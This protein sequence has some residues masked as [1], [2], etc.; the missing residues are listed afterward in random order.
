MLRACAGL[1]APSADEPHSPRSHARSATSGQARPGQGI[2]TLGGRRTECWSR[3]SMSNSSLPTR[4]ATPRHPSST[5]PSRRRRRRPRRRR[6][7]RRL[8]RDECALLLRRRPPPYA[9]ANTTTNSSPYAAAAAAALHPTPYALRPTPYALLAHE[10]RRQ[11][12]DRPPHATRSHPCLFHIA[13]AR[14]RHDAQARPTTSSLIPRP[15]PWLRVSGPGRVATSTRTSHSLTQMCRR[16]ASR[17]RTWFVLGPAVPPQVACAPV[18]QTQE[19]QTS[20][21]NRP[22]GSASGSGNR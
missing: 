21:T 8:L 20:H 12:I 19:Q 1:S 22:L 4:C 11:P 15:S 2:H 14:A 9:A 18:C 5:P 17:P 3:V 10:Q 7:R 13:R 6:R 16:S